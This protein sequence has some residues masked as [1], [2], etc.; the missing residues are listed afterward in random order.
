MTI[1]LLMLLLFI[2]A[3]I[4]PFV[5][6]GHGEL[7]RNLNRI[8]LGSAGVLIGSVVFSFL[9]ESLLG[10]KISAGFML[11]SFAVMGI[12]VLYK[13]FRL[14]TLGNELIKNDDI[15]DKPF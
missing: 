14:I 1:L 9:L 11:F 13:V 15:L 2:A 12:G 10:Q 5:N 4:V 8:I 6:R 7:F 3:L